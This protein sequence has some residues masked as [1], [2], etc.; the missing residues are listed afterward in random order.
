MEANYFTILA[1]SSIL[2]WRIPWTEEPDGLQ[3]CGH[4][5][6]YVTDTYQ[7]HYFRV[8]NDFIKGKRSTQKGYPPCKKNGG[9]QKQ[10]RKGEATHLGLFEF[11]SQSY[12]TK[13]GIKR[14][15]KFKND[16]N[17]NYR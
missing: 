16:Q 15:G 11:V 12:Y 3:L 4:K 7:Y 5:E 6:L 10:S 17:L 8:I 1:H 13:L 14:A 9:A 2:A